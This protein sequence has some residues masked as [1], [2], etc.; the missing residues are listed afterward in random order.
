MRTFFIICSQHGEIIAAQEM[1]EFHSEEGMAEFYASQGHQA[2][3]VSEEEYPVL[4]ASTVEDRHYFDG[5]RFVA[6][7]ERPSSRHVF[8][9]EQKAWALE[10]GALSKAQREKKAEVEVMRQAK[11]DSPIFYE[12]WL[13]DADSKA[14]TNV[15]AWMVNISNGLMVPLG[16]TWRDASNIDRPADKAFITG[17]GAAMVQRGSL[18]Y[19]Q[20]WEQKTYIDSLTSISEVDNFTVTFTSF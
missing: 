6:L 2:I 20:A 12:G 13:F 17:L 1:G 15:M 16:F 8:S 5:S 7:P 18:L 9:F 3:Q 19:Q 11:N 14:Q 10:E 4:K